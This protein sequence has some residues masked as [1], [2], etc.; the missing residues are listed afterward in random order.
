[1]DIGKM[2]EE[3]Y[4]EEFSESSELIIN[5]DEKL[6]LTKARD[7]YDRSSIGNYKIYCDMK[8]VIENHK[9]YYSLAFS[10]D[11]KY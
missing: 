1:M 7:K 11:K 5:S 8:T 10:F 9:K 4:K 3:F 2:V 6:L